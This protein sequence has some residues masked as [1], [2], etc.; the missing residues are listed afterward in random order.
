[1]IVLLHFTEVYITSF[2]SGRFTTSTAVNQRDRN[3]GNYIF[4]HFDITF[5]T[6]LTGFLDFAHLIY[7]TWILQVEKSTSNL[8]KNPVH[9]TQYFK[10]EDCKNQVQIYRELGQVRLFFWF[11]NF[12]LILSDFY[13]YTDAIISLPQACFIT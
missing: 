7:Q 6:T 3:L 13:S 5:L 12:P 4:V 10:L 9:Q 2:W 11:Q 1:M 8:G